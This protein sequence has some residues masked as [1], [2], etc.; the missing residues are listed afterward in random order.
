MDSGVSTGEA[1]F[2]LFTMVMP[3][4]SRRVSVLGREVRSKADPALV[5]VPVEEWG[6]QNPRTGTGNQAALEH[7]SH[8][9]RDPRGPRVF[10]FRYRSLIGG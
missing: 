3:F 10:S 8:G 4:R 9:V 2:I 5:V 7:E 1:I 6:I